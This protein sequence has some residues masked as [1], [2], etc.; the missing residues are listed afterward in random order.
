MDLDQ[1]C[2][3]I[4]DQFMEKSGGVLLGTDTVSLLRDKKQFGGF[5]VG[6]SG[7]DEMRGF[8][9]SGADGYLGKP[10]KRSNVLQKLWSC[11]NEKPVPGNDF[12]DQGGFYRYTR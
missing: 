11:L 6:C 10:I 3:I 7:S 5:I 4:I 1:Y 2:I 8:Y 9:E 12:V